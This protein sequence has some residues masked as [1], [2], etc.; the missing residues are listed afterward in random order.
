MTARAPPGVAALMVVTMKMSNQ[1][2]PI[3]HAVNNDWGWWR[4]QDYDSVVNCGR[5]A[6]RHGHGALS[7]EGSAGARGLR[8]LGALRVGELPLAA[9]GYQRIR[10]GP[11]SAPTVIE[12]TIPR[13]YHVRMKSALDSGQCRQ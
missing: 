13:V 3:P 4:S 9:S 10:R 1:D 12:S 8:S 6:I 11:S 5:I 2:E 7:K